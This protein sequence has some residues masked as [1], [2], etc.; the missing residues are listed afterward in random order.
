MSDELV[1]PSIHY[2]IFLAQNVNTMA[3]AKQ[4]HQKNSRCHKGIQVANS[5]FITL[6]I[7]ANR[8]PKLQTPSRTTVLHT[9]D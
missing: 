4:R 3:T 1:F 7:S 5:Y 9:G 8:P 6:L 2:A